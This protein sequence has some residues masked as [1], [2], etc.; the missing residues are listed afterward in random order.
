MNN[1]IAGARAPIDL[2]ARSKAAKRNRLNDQIFK[3]LGIAATMIGLIVLAYFI[4]DIVVDGIARI[5]WDFLSSLPSR[6]AEKAGILPAWAGS[7]WILG[8]TALFALPL[9]VAAGVYFEEYAKHSRINH[10]LEINIANLA[11]V[12]SIIYGILGLE[13]F[14]R[15][16]G[17][18]E[19][20][21]AG[22]FTLALLILPII[23]VATRE[24]IKAVP[25]TLREASYG[26][27]ATKWQTIKLQVLPAASG[28]ILTGTILALSRAVGETAPLIVIGAL[29][30]VPFVPSGPM[31]QFTVLPMQIFNW[32]S[33]P[34]A[35]FLVNAA[36]AIIVLL[37]ITFVMNGIA[38]YLRN[39]WQKN[40][41]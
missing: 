41:K 7:A 8:M 40:L 19:S 30:Y 34:Q 12:P 26:L 21:L 11:G 5:D 1:A 17:L 38:I 28:G 14:G 20:V 2:T 33:R 23:I 6:K 18:G 4:I 9:G 32:T 16:M 35:A 39:R 29:A 25:S 10:L 22:S 3:Y 31:D 24:A 27:G 36:A 15:M 13:V 37:A